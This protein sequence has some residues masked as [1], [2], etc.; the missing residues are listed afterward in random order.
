MR[1]GFECVERVKILIYRLAN[2]FSNIFI[3][4]YWEQLPRKKCSE[5]LQSTSFSP[6]HPPLQCSTLNTG[7]CMIKY[8]YTIIVWLPFRWWGVLW[9]TS[10]PSQRVWVITTCKT[11]PIS[12]SMLKCHSPLRIGAEWDDSHLL[13]QWCFHQYGMQTT[14]G[15]RCDHWSIVRSHL[16]D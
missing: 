6:I 5:T 11:K 12:S 3:Y 7:A 2:S 14:A 13:S 15:N 8:H 10:R 16:S 4:R 9:N 1:R